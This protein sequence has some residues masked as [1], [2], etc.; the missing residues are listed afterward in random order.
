MK[1]QKKESM[2][3]M[4]DG[5]LA[6]KSVREVISTHSAASE[7]FTSSD[8]V[9]AD[10][11]E[12]VQKGSP[13]Q[14]V[15]KVTGHKIAA[16][17]KKKD[18]KGTGLKATSKYAKTRSESMAAVHQRA[19]ELYDEIDSLVTKAQGKAKEIP[20][21]KYDKLRKQVQ[22][23]DDNI[24]KTEST[25][26]DGVGDGKPKIDQPAKDFTGGSVKNADSVAGAKITMHGDTKVTEPFKG[27]VSGGGKE[28]KPQLA[29]FIGAI[30]KVP[31]I[32]QG[33]AHVAKE[34]TDMQVAVRKCP[35]CMRHM[36]QDKVTGNFWCECG[37]NLEIGASYGPDSAIGK[38]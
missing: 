9:P 15:S 38:S 29:S 27:N 34:D 20:G 35:K 23:G 1:D 18:K 36:K 37:E 14:G 7:S 33:L 26:P 3:S 4:L 8:A 32:M 25:N 30:V 21:Y 17:G 2:D 5:I 6:G 22:T 24:N 16:K 31:T 28:V 13:S 19:I 10:T 11:G 12:G